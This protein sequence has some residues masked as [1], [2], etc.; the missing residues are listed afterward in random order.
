MNAA[1][2]FRL[3]ESSIY[4]YLHIL[5]EKSSTNIMQ[6]SPTPTIKAACA[7]T[8]MRSS[9]CA[10][11]GLRECLIGVV[12]RFGSSFTYLYSTNSSPEGPEYMASGT[13]PVNVSW[14]FHECTSGDKYL[15]MDLMKLCSFIGMMRCDQQ[16][17][18]LPKGPVCKPVA[19][20]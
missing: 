19:I 17:I 11:R 7:D 6:V 10:W 15:W 20:S 14:I 2:S 13:P 4:L 9:H 12:S 3:T 16:C 1:A 8:L 18:K 5:V